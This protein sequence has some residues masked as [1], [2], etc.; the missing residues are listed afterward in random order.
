MI[1]R[2]EK[3]NMMNKKYQKPNQIMLG[4][5]VV[6]FV[7]MF[8]ETALNVAIPN[9]M[10]EFNVGTGTVQLLVTGYLLM[11]GIILPLSSLLTRLFSTRKL[12]V[13]AMFDFIVGAVMSAVAM[14]F[15]V[16]FIGRL[17]Q[18]IAVGILLPLIFVVL[19]SVYP[20]EKR[21]SAM[22]LVGLVIMFAPAVGP[23]ISGIILSSSSWRYIF[24]LFVPL[25]LIALVLS[26]KFLVNVS[27][28]TKPKVDV[29][30]ILLSTIGFGGLVFGASLASE[31][32]WLSTIVL[33]CLA[34]G[35]LC[36]AIYV[37]RQL[38]LATP[39]LNLRAF[40]QSE[41]TVGTSLVLITF[42]IILASMYLI[43][44]LWQNGLGL[45][46]AMTGLIMLPAGVMNA[47]LSIVAG[48]LFDSYGAKILVRVGFVITVIGAVMFVF[49]PVNTSLW[50]IL[51][52][53]VVLM[54]GIPLV[55]SPAQMYGLNALRGPISADGSSIMNTLQQI[56]GAIA[57][58]ISTSLLTFG[59]SH[60]DASLNKM[61]R[62][63]Q[64]SHYGFAFVLVLA[65]VGFLISLKVKG[66][67]STVRK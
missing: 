59:N 43:P 11:I 62:F 38:T 61:S 16:L 42:G 6:G 60:S 39:I 7:G 19:L 29:L 12:A 4:L 52:A 21:G 44:M 22:G 55:V 56:A 13:F 36:L 49:T 54:I 17:I 9:L 51:M 47:V 18:G 67:A 65:I 25:I 30:S 63:I 27:E 3:G 41:F 45:S 34:V 35:L 10:Q 20:M 66:K 14:N 53:H 33:V 40:A 37:K 58:A 50:Y 26:L 32:G 57:T 24:W 28:V 23:T 46:P 1:A 8:S 2:I 5:L 48:R 15:T 64:S 31:E